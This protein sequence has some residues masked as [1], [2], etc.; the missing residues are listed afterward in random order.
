MNNRKLV[1][2]F[3]GA[4]LLVVLGTSAHAATDLSGIWGNSEWGQNRLGFVQPTVT[5]DGAL[6]VLG[7]AAPPP[8]ELA[9]EM[10]LVTYPKY[11]EEYLAKVDML[12]RNQVTADPALSCGNPGVPRIGAP[13]QIVQ[14]KNEIA[15]IYEDL[16]GFYWR[17]IPFGTQH[18]PNADP[19]YMG[20]PIARWEG[21]T[22]VVE[23]VN[24]VEDTWLTD[25]GAFHT[26]NMK[27]TERLSLVDDKLK[28]E[29]RVDDPEVLAEPW[30][31]PVRMLARGDIAFLPEPV[32]C[33][34][35]SI[36]EMI[37]YDDYHTNTR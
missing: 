32:P 33:I 30:I 17:V 24:F 29:A 23:T 7:C 26:P 27:V 34:E 4:A 28:Y 22:L 12:N 14:G 18:R 21:D 37:H 16:N 31:R 11:K 20:D 2:N 10:A 13:D 36:P 3:A 5:E 35:Q 15:F 9:A 25:N 6:C 19:S 8:A 1:F